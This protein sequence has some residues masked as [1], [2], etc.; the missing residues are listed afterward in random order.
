M[1]ANNGGSGVD[2]PATLTKAAGYAKD[3]GT[4]INGHSTQMTVAGLREFAALQRRFR[5]CRARGKEGG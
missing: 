1:D 4:F 3:V 5:E 2:L